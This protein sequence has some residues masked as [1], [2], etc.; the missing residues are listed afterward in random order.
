MND[1]F[2][3]NGHVIQKTILIFVQIL[4]SNQNYEYEK[5]TIL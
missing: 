5:T 4:L 3:K 2:R 1:F